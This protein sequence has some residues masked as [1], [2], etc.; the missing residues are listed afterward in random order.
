QDGS[1]ER[2]RSK[3]LV[4]VHDNEPSTQEALNEVV[5]R[6]KQSFSQ[7]S[8]LWETA[9]VCAAFLRTHRDEA[10]GLASSECWR[11]TKGQNALCTLQYSITSTARGGS[12]MNVLF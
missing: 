11:V 5:L 12:G 3:V 4:I 7:H 10:L 2:E 1:I 6:Y 9:R 8:V